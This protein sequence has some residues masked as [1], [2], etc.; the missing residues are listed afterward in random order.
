MCRIE[1]FFGILN[2]TGRGEGCETNLEGVVGGLRVMRHDYEVVDV[3][4][5]EGEK[6]YPD[7]EASRVSDVGFR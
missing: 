1:T 5:P 3:R 2:K 7:L 6:A 4:N